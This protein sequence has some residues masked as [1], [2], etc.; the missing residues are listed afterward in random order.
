MHLECDS[1]TLDLCLNSLGS[2]ELELCATQ[3]S[4]SLASCTDGL[5]EMIC[6]TGCRCAQATLHLRSTSW[7]HQHMRLHWNRRLWSTGEPHTIAQGHFTK[8]N[9]S[10][11]IAIYQNDSLK[12]FFLDSNFWRHVVYDV[13][14]WHDCIESRPGFQITTVSVDLL[15]VQSTFLLQI[16]GEST[17][18]SL[19]SYVAMSCRYNIPGAVFMQPLHWQPST[20]NQALSLQDKCLFF[21]SD[22]DMNVFNDSISL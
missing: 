7:I 21:G 5:K 12:T 14:F 19:D 2:L 9:S 13:P 4:S 3:T 10:K 22:L 11:G 18:V 8:Y 1:R 16:F 6:Y 17:L 20:V 15:C